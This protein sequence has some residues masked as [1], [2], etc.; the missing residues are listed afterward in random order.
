[1][2]D[3][4][5]L[6]GTRLFRLGLRPAWA[7]LTIVRAETIH[8]CELT[9]FDAATEL[10]IVT[11]TPTRSLGLPVTVNGTVRVNSLPVA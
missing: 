9:G 11:A 1:M 6:T 8:Y 2:L 7:I 10:I 3:T 4:Q 5:L